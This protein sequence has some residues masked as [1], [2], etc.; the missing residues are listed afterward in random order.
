MTMQTTAGTVPRGP[1]NCTPLPQPIGTGNQLLPRHARQL[2]NGEAFAA[3]QGMPLTAHVT[4]HLRLAESFTTETWPAFQTDLLD[5][6]SRWLR[7][8]GIPVAFA[9]VRENGPVKGEHL[10]LAL[11]LPQPMWGAFKRYLLHAGRFT[12]CGVGGEAIRISGGRFGMYAATM[13][14]GACRYVLKSL[15]PI[16]CIALGI[17]H[18]PTRPVTIK[19]CGVSASIGPKMRKA[20]GWP[21][22]KTVLE[23]RAH[24]HPAKATSRVDDNQTGEMRD[25]A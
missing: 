11:H 7:R 6:A 18:Q 17:R 9:W 22:L 8:K 19:R 23:M 14:A 1:S 25:A 24:L 13:R 16:T 12:A 15:S 10:H 20:A 2:I 4:I 3:S 5:K 21:D